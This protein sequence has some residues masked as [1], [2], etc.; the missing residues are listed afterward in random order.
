[1]APGCYAIYLDEAL[2]YIG[3]TQNLRR[4][5]RRYGISVEYLRGRGLVVHTPWATGRTVTIKV[6]R[7]RRFGDWL[8][9]EARLVRRLRPR[10][11]T[12]I[13]RIPNPASWEGP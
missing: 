13:P 6:R 4:R 1:M 10:F 3:Q 5:L 9:A 7:S 11:N 2:V 12:K 8:M